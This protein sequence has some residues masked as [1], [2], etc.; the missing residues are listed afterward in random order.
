V[1]ERA[2]YARV[3]PSDGTLV[4]LYC[5]SYPV[6]PAAVTLGIDDTV[7]VVH[8]AQ[9]LSFWN[10]HY[11]E[12]CFLP[13]HVYDTATGRPVAMLLRR[14]QSGTKTAMKS[15]TFN[16][17]DADADVI[18]VGAGV[19]GALTAEQIAGEGRAILMLDG[20]ASRPQ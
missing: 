9:Q 12:R 20:T 4:D 3:D 16:N 2:D 5:A 10:R 17:G 8:G 18:I 1:G 15:P 11:G 19:V 14:R 7:D 6:P 13:I